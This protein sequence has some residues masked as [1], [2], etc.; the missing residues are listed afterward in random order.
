MSFRWDQIQYRDDGKILLLYRHE[1]LFSEGIIKPGLK[2][3]DVGGWGVLSQRIEQEG[4]ECLILDLFTDDQYF[5]ERVR[6]QR[7]VQGNVLDTSLVGSL[8]EFD[9]VTCFEMLEHCNDQSLAVKNINS[10]LK[11][12]GIFAGTV[13]LPGKCHHEGEEGINFLSSAQLKSLL[14]GAGFSVDMVEET[15]S[16]NIDDE[17]CSLYFVGRK[18]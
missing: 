3:L 1:R 14:L 5:S 13:P 8:G 18:N 17:P 6:S 9:V 12:G 2:V 15:A 16:V 7:F 10:V 11:A 4:S